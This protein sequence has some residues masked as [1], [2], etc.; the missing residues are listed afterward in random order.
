MLLPGVDMD[1][2]ELRLSR[3]ALLA[4]VRA[5]EVRLKQL[6]L[7]MKV[8][9]G[10]IRNFE[11]RYGMSSK[12]FIERYEKGELGDGEDYV[13]WYSELKFLEIAE[14]EYE[15]LKRVMLD[16]RGKLLKGG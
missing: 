16:T 6:E 8:T 13:A 5:V 15:K 2:V 3:E 12:E 1:V 10:R 14:G 9:K 4:L 11:S 7:E